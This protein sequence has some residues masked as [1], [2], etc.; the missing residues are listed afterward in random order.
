VPWTIDADAP[1]L[2]CA[3]T[4]AWPAAGAD[5]LAGATIESAA[6]ARE[7]VRR[8]AVDPPYVLVSE[9][10]VEDDPSARGDPPAPCGGTARGVP[11][12]AL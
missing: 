4:T 8:V 6:S 7:A 1:R 2:G 3:H 11:A 5:A 9:L 12:L 10:S